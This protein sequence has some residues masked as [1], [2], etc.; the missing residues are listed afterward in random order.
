LFILLNIIRGLKFKLLKENIDTISTSIQFIKNF[1]NNENSKYLKSIKQIVVSVSSRI[2]EINGKFLKLAETSKKRI[3]NQIYINKSK[4][5]VN[6]LYFISIETYLD[7]P[8]EERKFV[9]R[10]SILEIQ[11]KT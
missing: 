6:Q 7:E 11:S 1:S 5:L 2:E 10:D 8:I 9:E 4:C 3:E